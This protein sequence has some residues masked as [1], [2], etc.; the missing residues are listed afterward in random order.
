MRRMANQTR[1]WKLA[2]RLLVA[3]IFVTLSATAATAAQTPS[4]AQVLPTAQAVPTAQAA[5]VVVQQT[6][7]GQNAPFMDTG[8]MPDEGIALWTTAPDRSVAAL[9]ANQAD[10]RGMISMHIAFTTSGFWQVTAHG[11]DSGKEVITAFNVGGTTGTVSATLAAVAIPTGTITTPAGTVAVA[12]NQ[13][14]TFTRGS[15]AA[16][17]PVSLWTTA[18]DGKTTA[19]DGASADRSG[20]VAVV[21]SFPTNG[22]WQVTAH[23]LTSGKEA[24][25]GFAVGTPLAVPTGIPTST[26]PPIVPGTATGMATYPTSTPIPKPP[27]P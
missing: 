1:R 12:V 18:P 2:G 20:N 8:F 14:A 9:P 17:E 10:R 13:L 3:A 4:T 25:G 15:F 26:A 27:V 11:L 6:A 7:M 24:I 5:T 21:V 19:L 23:G 22:Y 16:S